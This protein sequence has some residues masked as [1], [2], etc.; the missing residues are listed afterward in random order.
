MA[1]PPSRAKSPG[2]DVL[3]GVVLT[4]VGAGLAD[5]VVVWTGVLVKHTQM[6]AALIGF[7]A[8]VVPA[9]RWAAA[10]ASTTVWWSCGLVLVALAGLAGYAW[11]RIG[12]SPISSPVLRAL[13]PLFPVATCT[14]IGTGYLWR[15]CERLLIDHRGL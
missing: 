15:L 6:G 4:L 3:L 5:V 8:A 7:V 11:Q 1:P 2:I 10:R 13:V 9:H 12:M 14:S